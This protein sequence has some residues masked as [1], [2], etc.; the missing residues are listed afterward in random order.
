MSRDNQCAP[1]SFGDLNVKTGAA[2]RAL[3]VEVTDAG[4]GAGTWSVQVLPQSASTGASLE[5]PALVTLA[6][7]GRAELPVAA[8]ATAQAAAGDDYGFLVLR[9]GAQTRRIP[10]AFFVTRPALQDVQPIKLR[11]F[12]NGTTAGGASRVEAYRWPAAPFARHPAASTC[13]SRSARRSWR[14][15]PGSAWICRSA[16]FYRPVFTPIFSRV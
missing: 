7:G 2:R 8:S 11:R 4:G 12:Q 6:P 15:A 14:S 13:P 16:A 10:Y 1:L 9:R 5:A 3:L